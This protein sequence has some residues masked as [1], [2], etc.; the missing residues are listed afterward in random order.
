MW[1][2]KKQQKRRVTG[3]ILSKSI[4]ELWDPLPK[5]Q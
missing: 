5:A 4:G 2:Y 1:T 3:N